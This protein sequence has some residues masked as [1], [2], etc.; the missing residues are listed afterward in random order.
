[1]L[2]PALQIDA[3]ATGTNELLVCSGPVLVGKIVSKNGAYYGISDK[4][5]NASGKCQCDPLTSHVS[6]SLAPKFAVV[7]PQGPP[8]CQKPGATECDTPDTVLCANHKPVARLDSRGAVAFIGS[9]D[10]PSGYCQCM[11][12]KPWRLRCPD[13]PTSTA[14]S[15]YANTHINCSKKVDC[16]GME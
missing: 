2:L 6:C 7:E 13:F 9:T 10:K 4:A 3:V 5:S 8:I 12:E 16:S 14:F 1:M 11:P 15:K